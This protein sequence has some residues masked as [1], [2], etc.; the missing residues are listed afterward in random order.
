MS[1]DA[2]ATAENIV[3]LESLWRFGV[4]LELFMLTCAVALALIFYVLLRSVSRDLA[5]LATVFNL[6][7]IANRSGPMSS[8]S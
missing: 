2:T 4:A 1:G 7:S 3:L 8:V 6:V 5:L